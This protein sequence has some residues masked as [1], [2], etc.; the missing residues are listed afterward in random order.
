[1][2]RT[3]GA[4]R[5]L[6]VA[7]AI[8]VMAGG[9][10]AAKPDPTACGLVGGLVGFGSGFYMA[11]DPMQGYIFTAV[12]LGLGVGYAASDSDGTKVFCLL[13]RLGTSVYEGLGGA[14][15]ANRYN[16]RNPLSF[17]SAQGRPSFGLTMGGFGGNPYDGSHLHALWAQGGRYRDL[18]AAGER[19]RSL[20]P[21][22]QGCL[23]FDQQA[24]GAVW[25]S[26]F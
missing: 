20:Q 5:T 2:S 14:A 16:R 6:V 23:D 3:T 4:Y 1:M 9:P 25:S 19:W 26:S 11:R 10:V 15:A 24:V 18:A 8:G 13:A 22:W 21:T 12:D 7:L 17:S